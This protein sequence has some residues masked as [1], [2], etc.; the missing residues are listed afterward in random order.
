[1]RTSR[2]AVLASPASSW[3]GAAANDAVAGA[4]K[5][6]VDVAG[7]PG[8]PTVSAGEYAVRVS[9]STSTGWVATLT[10]A[11]GRQIRVALPSQEVLG[12]VT[13]PEVAIVDLA[14][15]LSPDIQLCF[16]GECG[17]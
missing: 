3:P 7:I 14:F 16:F 5:V 10:E 6:D 2:G 17:P 4:L 15:V 13:S 11:N 9:G 8:F 12:S 1:M